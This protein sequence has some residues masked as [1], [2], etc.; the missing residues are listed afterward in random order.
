[1]T[2]TAAGSG[3]GGTPL[4]F[5]RAV[6]GNRAGSVAGCRGR[7]NGIGADRFAFLGIGATVKAVGHI[8]INVTGKMG[9]CIAATGVT[10]RTGSARSVDM[11]IVA[12][13]KIR[14][15][16]RS[17]S[18]GVTGSTGHGRGRAPVFPVGSPT[19]VTVYA[20]TDVRCASFGDQGSRTTNPFIAVGQARSDAIILEDGNA[21]RGYGSEAVELRE[22]SV[23]DSNPHF[24]G[25]VA[26]WVG[27]GVVVAG[28]TTIGGAQES[29][30]LG[31][32]GAG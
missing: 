8:Q 1:M 20:T 18:I 14:T 9:Y 26:H 27:C 10:N 7:G 3:D 23:I 2:L 32:N 19:G 5:Q 12:A 21:C 31:M 13:D 17:G 4:G 29:A 15:T 28:I 6:A 24:N 11:L 25:L 22:I 16:L 30:V